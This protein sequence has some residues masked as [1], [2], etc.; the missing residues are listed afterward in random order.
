[1]YE[2]MYIVDVERL[3]FV[4][5]QPK[6]VSRVRYDQWKKSKVEGEPIVS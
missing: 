6:G 1:M 5:Y 2:V 4:S 3:E